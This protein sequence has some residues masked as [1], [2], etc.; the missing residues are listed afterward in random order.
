MRQ[1][2]TRLHIII[3]QDII[4]IYLSMDEINKHLFIVPSFYFLN[5]TTGSLLS[6][7]IRSVGVESSYETIVSLS[8]S[9]IFLNIGKYLYHNYCRQDQNQPSSHVLSRKHW[10][11]SCPPLVWAGQRRPELAGEHSSKDCLKSQCY[12]NHHHHHHHH[13]PARACC[14]QHWCGN[15]ESSL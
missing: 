14:C 7:R 4:Y 9:H 6:E 13:S 12:L 3:Q 5:Q 11:L 1:D 8:L 15:S 10:P 2:Y